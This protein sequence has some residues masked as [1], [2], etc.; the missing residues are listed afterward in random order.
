MDPI[1]FRTRNVSEMMF[2][3]ADEFQRDLQISGP[4][5]PKYIAIIS[6]Y[7]VECKG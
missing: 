3:F 2:L 5:Y 6:E 7:L 1:S 4:A